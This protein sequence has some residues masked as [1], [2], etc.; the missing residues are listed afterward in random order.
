MTFFISLILI[1][2]V[3][4]MLIH[5]IVIADKRRIASSYRFACSAGI[6]VDLFLTIYFASKIEPFSTFQYVVIVLCICVSF[7]LLI[8]LIGVNSDSEGDEISFKDMFLQISLK[9]EDLLYQ[10]YTAKKFASV[11]KIQYVSN[12]EVQELIKGS[13]PKKVIADKKEYV[14]LKPLYSPNGEL[15]NLEWYGEFLENESAA[16]Y[17]RILTNEDSFSCITNLDDIL[18]QLIELYTNSL[19]DDWFINPYG[20]A[21]ELEGKISSEYRGKAR[22]LITDNAIIN[23]HVEYD[24]KLFYKKKML[25]EFLEDFIGVNFM[26]IVT[27][28]SELEIALERLESNAR[29]KKLI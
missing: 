1:I 18:Y 17:S 20:F 10:Q 23:E 11:K 12:I 13:S 26:K 25:S 28:N 22:L 4:A 6:A 5:G 2:F 8:L 27:N 7:M 9:K 29:N 15:N 3:I 16:V 24:Q 19:N 21:L 14:L